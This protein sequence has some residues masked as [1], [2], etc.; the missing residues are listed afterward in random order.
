M[1][2]SNTKVIEHVHVKLHVPNKNAII[3]VDINRAPSHG[4]RARFL[5][6]VEKITNCF[7]SRELNVLCGDIN[8]DLLKLDNIYWEISY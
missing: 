8:I 3:F 6:E 5:F 4:V 1:S 7:S 2:S